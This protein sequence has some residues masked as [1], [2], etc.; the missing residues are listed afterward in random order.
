ML[1]VLILAFAYGCGCGKTQVTK[2][3]GADLS[4]ASQPPDPPQK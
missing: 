4:K 1:A 2:A 3:N